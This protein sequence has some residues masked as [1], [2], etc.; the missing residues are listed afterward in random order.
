[1]VGF[2]SIVLVNI[3]YYT[4]INFLVAANDLILATTFSDCAA[5]PDCL[6]ATLLI[7]Y[8]LIGVNLVINVV[9]Q[10]PEFLAFVPG[11]ILYV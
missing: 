4:L 7:A 2:L 3:I 8:V 9:F 6:S 1:M 11:S 10:F 5:L